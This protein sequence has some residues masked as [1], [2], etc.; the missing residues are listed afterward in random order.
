MQ[1]LSKV[2]REIGFVILTLVSAL[3]I[4]AVLLLLAGNDPLESY[5][6]LFWGA[7]GSIDRIAETLVKT[8]ILIIISLGVSV[9]FKAQIW[10]IGSEGQFIFGAIFAFIIA[11]YF[12]DSYL[13]LVLSAIG[14][15]IGGAFWGSIVGFL[16][17]RFNAN[18]VITTLMLSYIAMYFLQWLVRNPLNDP[19]GYG[20]PQTPVLGTLMRLPIIIPGTRLHAGIFIAI[21][22]V[23]IIYLLWRTKLGF[24]IQLVGESQGVSKYSGINVN[25]TIILTMLISGGLAGI[26]GWTEIAGV[27]YRLLD[28]IGYG[29]NALAIVAALLGNLNPIG[30]LVSSFFFSALMVGGSTMQRL[31][32]VPFSIIHIIQ[33]VVI[34]FAIS[35]VIFVKGVAQYGNY[36]RTLKRKLFD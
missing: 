21:F 30:I 12:K 6:L 22:L 4:G 24:S 28:N 29:Y 2:G 19:D 26:A 17:V 13:L 5:K 14:G 25:K 15:F 33:G 32:G 10:N 18:E 11:F 35:R 7:F 16:K 3:I 34:I 31:A 8:S 23:I 9:A 27:H 1:Q 36:I 20:F